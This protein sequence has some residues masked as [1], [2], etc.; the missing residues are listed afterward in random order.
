[1]TTKPTTPSQGAADG[2]LVERTTFDTEAVW[3][4]AMAVQHLNA[5][6]SVIEG[7]TFT[8]CLIEGPALL[9]AIDNVTFENC[10]MGEALEPR[11]LL[12]QPMGPKVAG[13]IAVS[14]TRFVRCRFVLVSFT[15]H[16]EFLKSVEETLSAK[17]A[18]GATA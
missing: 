16:P 8:D 17:R 9:A 15:G 1:M 13:G 2:A 5:G 18:S 6:K 14:N 3:L 11:S 10:N 4:P 12:V 7:K